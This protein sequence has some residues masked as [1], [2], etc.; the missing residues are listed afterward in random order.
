M[1]IHRLP[2]PEKEQVELGYLRLS[3]SAPVIMAQ[4]MGL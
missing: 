3:D 2:K 1:A 4:E